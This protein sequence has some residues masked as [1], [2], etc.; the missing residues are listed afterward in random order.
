MRIHRRQSHLQGQQQQN[1]PRPLQ[2]RRQQSRQL[3]RRSERSLHRLSP[4]LQLPLKRRL[5]LHGEALSIYRSQLQCPRFL[6]PICRQ[7]LRLLLLRFL[8]TRLLLERLLRQSSR[9]L[10]LSWTQRRLSHAPMLL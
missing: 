3:R 6:L 9:R 5:W 7:E 4:I 1:L 2:H 10:L 8:L